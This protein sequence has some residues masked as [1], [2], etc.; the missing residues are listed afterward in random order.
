[1]KFLAALFLMSL[2]FNDNVAGTQSP[3]QRE[4]LSWSLKFEDFSASPIYEG[5]PARPLLVTETDR[6]FRTTIRQAV[7]KGPNFAGH[8]A[9][10]Y[11]GCGSSC[12]SFV[13]V[14]IVTGRVYDDSTPFSL[15]GVPFQG[16]STGRDYEGLVYERGSR[17]LIADGCPEDEKCGTYYYEWKKNRFTLLRFDPLEP[18][19]N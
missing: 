4:I 2:V 18:S 15:I 19:T 11:W 3:P 1:M 8:Y 7:R 5:R 13:V 10:A 12:T 14:D 17:L 6:M 16:T 9:I